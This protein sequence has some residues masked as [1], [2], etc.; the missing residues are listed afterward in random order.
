MMA[1]VFRARTAAYDLL[2]ELEISQFPVS[3]LG[4]CDYFGIKYD[5]FSAAP[6]KLFKHSFDIIKAQKIEAMSYVSHGETIILFDDSGLLTRRR[7]T[8][9]HEIGHIILKHHLFPPDD[10]FHYYPS[11]DYKEV[12]ANNF[13]GELLR[14]A[15]LIRKFN[16][17]DAEIIMHT[18]L[19]SRECAAVGLNIANKMNLAACL[20]QYPFFNCYTLFRDDIPYVS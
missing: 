4:I 20:E 11:Q 7:F 19:V 10:V 15:A 3:P 6:K 17:T 14:P 5:T 13:A 1:D 9:A 18:F 8:I 16:L 2:E 12:E